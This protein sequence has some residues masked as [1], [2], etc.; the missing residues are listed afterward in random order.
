MKRDIVHKQ[1]ELC[2]ATT[3]GS[4]G[5][6]ERIMKI[7]NE[8]DWRQRSREVWLKNGDK[9][10][11]YFH[12]CQK[13]MERVTCHVQHCLDTTKSAFL[14][15]KFLADECQVVQE[16]MQ[17]LCL[18]VRR[19]WYRHNM[20]FHNYGFLLLDGVLSWVTAYGKEYS[21]ADEPE[22]RGDGSNIHKIEKWIPPSSGGYKVN[23]DFVLDAQEGHNGVGIIIR[24]DFG[25]VM[26]SSAHRVM[27]AFSVPLAEVVVILKGMQFACDS[28]LNPCIFESDVWGVVDI[29]NSRVP[30]LSEI[31]LVISDILRL[32]DGPFN[33]HVTFDPRFMNKAAHGPAKLGLKIAN[34]LFLM[35]ECPL[36]LDSTV[37]GNR[38]QL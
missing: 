31:G 2:A 15:S 4:I 27:G 34:N 21:S 24:N 9:N 33:L 17:L 16:E 20:F 19:I 13:D 26:A 30:P 37:M 1:V 11:K 28:G 10:T 32:L 12:P 35:E 25:D 36:C 29:I 8:L 38:P 18:V 7:E 23:T 6:W 5:D 14:D 3:Q 22:V